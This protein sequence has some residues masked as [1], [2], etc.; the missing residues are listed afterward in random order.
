MSRAL[1]AAWLALIVGNTRL[2]W[3]FFQQQ[4]L[5]GSWHTPHLCADQVSDLKRSGFSSE[6]WQAIALLT[7]A[8]KA[9]LPWSPLSPKAIWM[10]AA[11]PTQAA[12]WL[13]L[14]VSVQQVQRSNFPIAGLYPTFGLDRALTLLGAG[15]T[16]G[17][18]VLVIDGG[19]ALTFT[20]GGSQPGQTHA[21]VLYGGAI[22]PGIRLQG[23]ALA[24]G[25]AALGE[26]ITVSQSLFDSIDEPIADSDP[27]TLPS[28][29][30][31]NTAGAI[32]SGL[33][34]GT[35]AIIAD[36]L[37]D[38]WRQFPDGKAVLTGGDGPALHSLLQQRTPALAARVQVDSNLMFWGMRAY[39][40]A[41]NTV[42]A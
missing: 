24:L 21:A 33:T 42:G 22:L 23:Q 26:A 27:A 3:G 2:H 35:A 12:L 36:Y 1:S 41:C 18:P 32:A 13:K 6:T 4:K 40:Q 8:E 16:L 19:T 25:T 34:Y 11:V 30:A 10:A 20:A 37:T 15:N 31:T 29:W 9:C 17:W 28:R 38:W 5:V 7:P 14:P 39:R